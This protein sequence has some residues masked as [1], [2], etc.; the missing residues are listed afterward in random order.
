MAKKNLKT[1]EVML[2][3]LNGPNANELF[4]PVALYWIDQLLRKK[5]PLVTFRQTNILFSGGIDTH[6]KQPWFLKHLT[7]RALELNK[8]ESWKKYLTIM[9]DVI[10]DDPENDAA[11]KN[12]I[13][14]LLFTDAPDLI[15]KVT[16]LFN[17][18]VTPSRRRLNL[19]L[20]MDRIVLLRALE[21]VL[22]ANID[23][24]LEYRMGSLCHLADLMQ[25]YHLAQPQDL[26][27]DKIRELCLRETRLQELMILLFGSVNSE[28][29]WYESFG[30]F[31]SFMQSFDQKY[32]PDVV[33]ILLLL[34]RREKVL[35]LPRWLLKLHL[36]NGKF[37]DEYFYSLTNFSS[38][39]EITDKDYEAFIAEV[40]ADMKFATLFAL[41]D[42]NLPKTLW[43]RDVLG[44][45]TRAEKDVYELLEGLQPR[46]RWYILCWGLIF[47][48][49]REKSLKLF[50]HLWD[51]NT[52]VEELTILVTEIEKCRAVKGPK[53]Y[54]QS[55]EK[56]CKKLCGKFSYGEEKL[57]RVL[58][59]ASLLHRMGYKD[60]AA[61]LVECL[62]SEKCKISYSDFLHIWQLQYLPRRSECFEHLMRLILEKVI[63]DPFSAVQ[64]EKFLSRTHWKTYEIKVAAEDGL[65]RKLIRQFL[66]V[67]K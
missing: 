39:E 24:W 8:P 42:K 53:A 57:S 30:E 60:E 28:K 49:T 36:C 6:P 62:D 25:I 13:R 38:S 7:L 17:H 52:T 44:Y 3:V 12:L 59:T 11:Y 64:I 50:L 23:K 5:E 26:S 41:K 15:K 37:R 34:P 16:E 35:D 48:D 43:F 27:Q 56:I 19:Y 29:Y 31:F 58:T 4:Y 61:Q 10:T 45:L 40:P 21:E 14:V 47:D 2:S 20:L 55:L 67:G 66:G 65:S 18:P 33:R 22:P 54:C 51:G 9:R 1:A 63:F 46:D 32:L